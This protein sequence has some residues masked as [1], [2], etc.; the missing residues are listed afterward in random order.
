[1]LIFTN[2]NVYQQTL[3]RFTCFNITFIC[4]FSSG[5]SLISLH[6]ISSWFFLTVW[7]FCTFNVCCVTFFAK[8]IWQACSRAAAYTVK[9]CPLV[10]LPI[11][12]E[13]THWVMNGL[14][15]DLDNLFHTQN[16]GSTEHVFMANDLYCKRREKRVI[17]KSW[18]DE[19]LF[20][21]RVRS[22]FL[23]SSFAV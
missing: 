11:C 2:M 10:V 21:W 16:S 23:F 6:Q 22:L 14:L 15:C 19:Y 3:S 5:N 4:T 20:F 1:M 7:F 17:S 8:C 12:E 9:R 18:N 13:D